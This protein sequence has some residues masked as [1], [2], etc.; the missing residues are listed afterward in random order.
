MP[1]IPAPG[2]V[3][4][5]MPLTNNKEL[6]DLRKVCE[7]HL[8]QM[9]HCKQCRAD[10]IGTLGDDCSA[11]F[12]EGSTKENTKQKLNK[13]NSSYTFA[14]VSRNGLTIDEHFGHAKEFHIYKYDNKQILLIE[15]RPVEVGTGSYEN[16]DEEKDTLD[17]IIKT[18]EDCD[19]VLVTRIGEIPKKLLEDKGKKVI[20]TCG[21]VAEEILKLVVT[22]EDRNQK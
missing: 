16:C 2:S 1:L 9:Y 18:I 7:V 6:N 10:A 5:H 14:V 20:E 21:T 3:F 22:L 19:A 15:K 17:K 11:E 12:R 13:T 8:K 4:E